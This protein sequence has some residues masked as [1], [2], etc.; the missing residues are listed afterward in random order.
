MPLVLGYRFDPATMLELIA[1]QRPTF[2]VAAITAY[3]ALM[4]APGF[5]GAD[6]PA[7]ARPTPAG[8]PS[9]PRSSAA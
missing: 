2:T 4:R 6:C 7:C 3:Q 5:D 9:R 1:R 8:R